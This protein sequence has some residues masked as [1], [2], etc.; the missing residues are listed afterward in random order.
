MTTRLITAPATEPV[1]LAE[2]KLHLKVDTAITEDDT[3]ISSLIISARQQA[4]QIL[5]RSL[6]TQTWEK[7]LDKFPSGDIELLWPTIISMT[8]I[9]YLDPTTQ[10]EVTLDSDQY[11]LD[12]DSEPGWVLPAYGVEWPTALDT[13][14]AVRVRYTA[15]YGDAASV[16]ACIKSWML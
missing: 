13:V 7:V 6:I 2:A 14:N 12:K 9:K 8:S 11:S 1:T 15:G 5:G 4:E 3:L 10:L 16:P